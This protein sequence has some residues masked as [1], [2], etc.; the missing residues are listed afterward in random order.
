MRK[1]QYKNTEK[2][3]I[4]LEAYDEENAYIKEDPDRKYPILSFKKMKYL[5]DPDEMLTSDGKSGAW[6]IVKVNINEHSAKGIRVKDSGLV[7]KLMKKF[8]RD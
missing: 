7:K 3:V 1:T 8:D 5:I 4:E 6:K 2:E